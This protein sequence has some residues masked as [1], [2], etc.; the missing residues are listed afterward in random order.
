MSADNYLVVDHDGEHF[1][2]GMGFA[3]DNEG[4]SRW[5][6]FDTEGEVKAHIGSYA[7][8]EYGVEWTRAARAACGKQQ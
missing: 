6:R 4:P 2:V 8:I 5:Q 1:L 3:S 7:V